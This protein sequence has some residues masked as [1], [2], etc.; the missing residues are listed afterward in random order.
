MHGTHTLPIRCRPA[1]H[2]GSKPSCKTARGGGSGG[3]DGGSAGGVR[4]LTATLPSII[5]A[6]MLGT[7]ATTFAR[8]V[9]FE[10]IDV[11]TGSATAA[12]GTAIV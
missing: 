1:G 5:I 12:L 4:V 10:T 9:T 6:L 11:I 2:D 3:L 8:A 7:V